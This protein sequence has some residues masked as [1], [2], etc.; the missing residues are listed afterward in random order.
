MKYYILKDQVI[1]NIVGLDTTIG[2]E[3]TRQ[4]HICAIFS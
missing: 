4:L 2:L 1:I 3:K